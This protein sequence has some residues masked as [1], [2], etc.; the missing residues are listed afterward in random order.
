MN[1]S[2]RTTFYCCVITLPSPFLP[3]KT[4]KFLGFQIPWSILRI[5]SFDYINYL[6]VVINSTSSSISLLTERPENIFQSWFACCFEWF[7]LY[8]D[9]LM[10]GC[11]GELKFHWWY[12]YFLQC[13]SLPGLSKTHEY[14]F[15]WRDLIN[16]VFGNCVSSLN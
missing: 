13:I 14:W 3:S 16:C 1:L 10:R 12:L 8:A 5:K 6:L 9:V 11:K 2:I 4:Y 7:Y 15:T